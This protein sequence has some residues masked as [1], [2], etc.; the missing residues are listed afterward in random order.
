MQVAIGQGVS[1][2]FVWP[3]RVPYGDSKIFCGGACGL[4]P[5]APPQ[6][7]H[8]RLAAS[9]IPALKTFEKPCAIGYDAFFGVERDEGGGSGSTPTKTQI[10]AECRPPGSHL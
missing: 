10:Q 7:I 9:N 1:K 2:V 4:R 6:K 3:S 8:W 5:Q